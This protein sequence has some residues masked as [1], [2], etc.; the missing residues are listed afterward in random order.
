VGRAWE[1][2]GAWA[3]GAVADDVVLSA[4]GDVAYLLDELAPGGAAFVESLQR[5][6]GLDVVP[7]AWAGVVGRLADVGALVPGVPA[8]PLRVSVAPVGAADAGRADALAAAIGRHLAPVP[9]AGAEL[10][11]VVRERSTPATVVDAVRRATAPML[12]VDLSSPGSVRLGPWWSPPATACPACLV[13]G[14]A[15]LEAGAEADLDA[16]LPGV[17]DGGARRRAVLDRWLPAVASLVALQVE[18]VAQRASVLAG[19]AITWDLRTGRSTGRRVPQLSW[20][21]GCGSG[22]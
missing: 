14:E 7:E 13:H 19:G 8:A 2:S 16:D 17:A 15:G 10:V 9:T 22:S 4:G 12:L 11:V 20:C 1:W 5:A 18:A 21:P 3:A 6:G